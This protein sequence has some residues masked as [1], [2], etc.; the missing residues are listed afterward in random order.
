MNWVGE[1]NK[2]Q[3]AYGTALE[4]IDRSTAERLPMNLAMNLLNETLMRIEI[5]SMPRSRTDAIYKDYDANVDRKV[6]KAMVEHYLAN[7]KPEDKIDVSIEEIDAMFDNSVYTSLEKKNAAVAAGVDLDKDPAKLFYDKIIDGLRKLNPTTPPS[8][9]PKDL[10]AAQKAFTAG[11]L[12]WR[13][14]EAIYPDANMTCRLTFGNVKSYSPKDGVI[15]NYYTTLKGVMEKE[16]PD[17]YEFRV[18]ARLKEIYET[19]DYGQYAN[20]NGE[21]P[22]C[23]LCNLDITGGNS[24]SPVLDADGCLIGLAFD[25]NWEAMSGDVMFEPD[26]QRCICVDIRFVLLMMDKFGGAGYLLDEMNIVR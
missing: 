23:F 12:E 19:K 4:T 22:A 3:K 8:V 21:M 9:N 15:Y 2:R 6:A 1:K 16:D 26:L 11:Q 10:A 13:K 24:G 14:G 25:G 17:N 20:K 7:V 5:I 18:P